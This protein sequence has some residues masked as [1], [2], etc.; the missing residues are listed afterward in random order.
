MDKKQII[1]WLLAGD[2]S[3]QYQV[4]R[5]LLAKERKDLQ[6]RIATEGWGKEILR[7][8][9]PDR[10]W[11]MRFYQPKWTSTHYTLLDLRNLNL[12]PDNE[13]ELARSLKRDSLKQ[14]SLASDIL[15]SF[16]K[17]YVVSA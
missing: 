11:G 4:Y 15:R 7:M 6:D 3:I 12:C 5:D 17:R 9:N 10:H 8:R 2:V 14:R 16:P 1:E 13:A